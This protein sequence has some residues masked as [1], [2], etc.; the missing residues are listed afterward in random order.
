[1]S[2]TT[3]PG[4]RPPSSFVGIVHYASTERLGSMLA[5]MEAVPAAGWGLQAAI[6]DN[7]GRLQRPEEWPEYAEIIVPRRNLGFAGGAARLLEEARRRSPDVAV[8]ANDDLEW[9]EDLIALLEATRAWEHPD[10]VVVAPALVGGEQGSAGEHA[11]HWDRVRGTFQGRSG[12]QSARIVEPP[13]YLC[14][15]CVALSRNAYRRINFD[16]S[17][18]LYGEDVDLS[19]QAYAAGVAVRLCP[20]ARVSHAGGVT[21]DRYPARRTYYRMR[22]IL[23]VTARWAERR[24]LLLHLLRMPFKLAL[25]VLY[26]V[27]RRRVAAA[28]AAVLG[29][30]AGLRWLARDRSGHSAARRRVWEQRP[31]AAAG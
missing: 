7:S 25:T 20:D 24:A 5:A 19:F 23:R 21:L 3:G 30:L 11:V 8:I 28:L 26:H 27:R 17:L 29:T 14:G 13:D 12:S 2:D 16:P 18:F 9:G 31:E 4:A 22:N 1:M 6:L 15:A 10:G